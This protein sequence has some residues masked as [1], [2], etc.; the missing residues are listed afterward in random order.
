MPTELLS[1]TIGYMIDN[2]SKEVYNDLVH[3]IG[4]CDKT[5]TLQ[6]HMEHLATLDMTL[7]KSQSGSGFRAINN[8][9][10]K[11][12]TRKMDC[13]KGGTTNTAAMAKD[14]RLTNYHSDHVG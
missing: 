14:N 12:S 2:G 13:K 1:I 7:N 9:T 8:T 10:T 5:T 11:V 6:Q 3:Y 4:M